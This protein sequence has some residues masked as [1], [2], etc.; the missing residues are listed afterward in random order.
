M[1][2]YLN[3]SLTLLFFLLLFETC[4]LKIDKTFRD[5]SFNFSFIFIFFWGC[6]L[7]CKIIGDIVQLGVSRSFLARVEIKVSNVRLGHANPN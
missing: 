6:I 5:F 4:N 7:T 3:A 1:D 2:F